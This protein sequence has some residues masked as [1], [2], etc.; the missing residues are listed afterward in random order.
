MAGDRPQ[1]RVYF[2]DSG[3]EDSTPVFV[4]AGYVAPASVWAEVEA[5]LARVLRL[6]GVRAV[7]MAHLCGSR[8]FGEFEGWTRE[9]RDA[10]LDEVGSIIGG[11]LEHGVGRGIFVEDLHRLLTPAD[12]LFTKGTPARRLAAVA[13]CL[14]M[15]IEWLAISW[16]GRPDEAKIDVVVEAGTKGLGQAVPYLQTLAQAK[17]WGEAIGSIKV[18]GKHDEVAIQTGDFLAY[19][20]YQYLLALRRGETYDRPCWRRSLGGARINIG[21]LTE[22]AIRSMLASFQLRDLLGSEDV[23]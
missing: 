2:D 19:N 18:I 9:R 11:H 6:V 10:L 7:K 16:E 4:V 21:W 20:V 23:L 3:H 13:W 14:R 1:L 15:A 5:D 22:P 12:D 8:G 17:P